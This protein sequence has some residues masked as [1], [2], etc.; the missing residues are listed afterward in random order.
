MRERPVTLEGLVGLAD[1]IGK[2]VVA[3]E[4]TEADEKGVWVKRSMEAL[5]EQ[6]LT[7]LVVPK[8]S[9][10]MGQGLSAL[11][12]ICETLGKHYASVGLCYGMHC[13]GTAVIAAKATSWQK[14][15][16]LEAIGKGQH[17]TTLAL[18]EAGTG[19]HFY[20]PQTSLMPV[21]EKSFL[22]NGVKTF[23]TNGGQVDSYVLSTMAASDEADPEQFSCIV[24]DADSPGMHWGKD[25][26]GLG[27]RGNSSRTLTLENVTIEGR[28]ILGDRGDQLWYIF[29][30]VAPYFIIS[31]S[32]TYLGI[33][34][35]ALQEARDILLKR[36]YAHNGIH[37]AQVSILQHRLGTLW[38]RVERTRTLIYNAAR[39]ADEGSPNATLS[40]LAAKAEVASCCVDTV[41]DVLTLAGGIGFSNNSTLGILLRD[42]RAA[43]VMAPTTDM[44]YAWIGRDLLDQPI[45]SE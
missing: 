9:G 18:S 36:Y 29:N 13:V 16:Y 31:M 20:I 24:L 19:A 12:R 41:N 5:R 14:E 21:S 30:V 28:Q 7:A 34:E 39:Q 45:L 15:H 11:A 3:A 32:G 33:A 27:M 4:K 37:L 43:H 38:A 8:E 1:E 17:L 42:A 2:T 40:L 26:D 23:V 44:L 6:G 10:G 22:I 25:W 35:R